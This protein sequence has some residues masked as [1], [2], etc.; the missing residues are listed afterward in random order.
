[1]FIPTLIWGATAS[2][3]LL[4]LSLV[5]TPYLAYK[6]ADRWIDRKEEPN[7]R[8]PIHREESDIYKRYSESSI[9]A[10]TRGDR[11]SSRAHSR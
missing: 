9:R 7:Y 3:V 10:R 8:P 2:S 1:M 5:A 11:K 4:P 6:F